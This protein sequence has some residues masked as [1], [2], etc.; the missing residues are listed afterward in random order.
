MD[1][2][3][4]ADEDS[5]QSYLLGTPG[6]QEDDQ[7]TEG[8]A[9][10]GRPCPAHGRREPHLSVLAEPWAIIR[11]GGE[12]HVAFTPLD[13]RPWWAERIGGDYPYGDVSKR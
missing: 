9:G 10:A 13:N 2:G 3:E 8:L 6:R 12:F 11:P 7:V 4:Q 1:C 5:D